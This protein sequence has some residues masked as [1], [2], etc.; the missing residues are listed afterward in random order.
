MIEKLLEFVESQD[1]SCNN[2]QTKEII[3]KSKN[4][5]DDIEDVTKE[6]EKIIREVLILLHFPRYMQVFYN[7]NCYRS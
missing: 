1:S 3:D 2:V 7:V 4:S 5:T 6:W